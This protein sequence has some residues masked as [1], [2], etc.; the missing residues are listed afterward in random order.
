MRILIGGI[1]NI[2]WGDDGFGVELAQRLMR[3]RWPEGVR[4]TDFGI[5]GI[6]LCYSLVD[7]Y[8]AYILLDAVPS[9][10]RPGTLQLMDV[11]VRNLPRVAPA[12]PDGHALDPLQVL[13]TVKAMGVVPARVYVLGCTPLQLTEEEAFEGRIGL[14]AAVAASIEQALE[15]VRLLVDSIGRECLHEAA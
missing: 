9:G 12:V 11:D 5:R 14:S 1:G 8:D 2:F 15:M 3:E 7:G 4:I 6:D 13:Q 10:E